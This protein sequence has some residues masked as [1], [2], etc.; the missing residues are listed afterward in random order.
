[1]YQDQG[2]DEEAEPLF[3]RA[4][5]IMEAALGEGHPNT[6]TVRQNAEALQETRGN[7]GGRA[8]RENDSTAP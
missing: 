2:H 4:L 3:Q 7:D 5:A 6:A 1:L 8:T